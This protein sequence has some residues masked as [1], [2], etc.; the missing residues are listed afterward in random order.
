MKKQNIKLSKNFTLYE[1]M[2]GTAMSVQAVELAWRD[3]TEDNLNAIK[4]FIPELEDI[5]TYVNTIYVSNV[6]PDKEIG[7]VITSG[8][9]SIDWEKKQGRSGDSQHTIC[10][11]DLQFSNVSKELNVK[12]I[13]DI[14]SKYNNEK[15]MGGLAIKKPT[16]C[17]TK[18]SNV[19]FI[20]LDPRE[21]TKEQVKRG[22]GAR[23]IY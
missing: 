11:V 6:I 14:F 23:W 17:N 20:H 2:Q 13:F 16:I 1:Y 7:I 10:A 3:F 21:P 19:G 4:E 12:I 9:R 8:F 15:Y 18:I 5:R 22:Y